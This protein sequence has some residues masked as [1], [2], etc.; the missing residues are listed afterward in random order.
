MRQPFVEPAK[1]L[2]E[3]TS[4]GAPNQ[5]R[6]IEVNCP[7]LGYSRV[8]FDRRETFVRPTR[9]R[10]R[11]PAPVP[12][13]SVRANAREQGTRN[14]KGADS[15]AIAM[16]SPYGLRDDEHCGHD[17]RWDLSGRCHKY[18][19]LRRPIRRQRYCQPPS[20]R[21]LRR[22]GAT[23]RRRQQQRWPRRCAVVGLLR[24]KRRQRHFRGWKHEFEL[25]VQLDQLRLVSRRP[26]CLAIL[27]GRAILRHVI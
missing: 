10:C 6:R 14:V 5:K 9:C 1:L 12:K 19:G 25:Q 7:N 11:Q 22:K 13:C 23:C 15:A 20:A 18:T 16:F 3:I 17:A 27:P 8:A 26:F 2:S 21:V 4:I 24:T